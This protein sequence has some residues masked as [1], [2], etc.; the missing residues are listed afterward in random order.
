[1]YKG[2]N[3]VLT[4]I[5]AVCFPP[6]TELFTHTK[7]SKPSQDHDQRK[8]HG[9]QTT[10]QDSPRDSRQPQNQRC[11]QVKQDAV[12]YRRSNIPQ[13]G[14][15]CTQQTTILQRR[16]SITWTRK[17]CQLRGR[18]QS[19]NTLKPLRRIAASK[20]TRRKRRCPNALQP[21]GRIT[22]L[23]ESPWHPFEQ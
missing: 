16:S 22:A 11:H 18:C 19:P 7:H 4:Y 21:P 3:V 2:H 9:R 12:N 20:E 1:M 17:N 15:Q 14:R 13:T 10:L 6:P 5:L 8:H 23:P